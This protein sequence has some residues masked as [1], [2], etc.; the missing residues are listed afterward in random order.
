[1]DL[2]KVVV[3]GPCRIYLNGVDLG[4]TLGGVTFRAAR[5]LTK[6]TADRHGS[7]PIDYVL[8]GTEATVEFTLAQVGYPQLDKAMPETSS[9]D[10]SGTRDRIDI[11]ADA[12]HSL[13]QYAV[14]MVIHPER[15]APTDYSEDITLYMVVQTGDVEL[16]YR[17]DA[18]KT[19][20]QR[21]TALVSEAY[22]AG[23][24]L[25]HIGPADV[26]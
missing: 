22:G 1:M 2:S 3:A 19:L 23:R 24:R 11:G 8:S 16:P 6:V 9:Y 26:S 12:G 13:R 15:N 14:P 5:E 17:I 21:Y 20:A 4:H 25:G 7:T 18:Q 10:G